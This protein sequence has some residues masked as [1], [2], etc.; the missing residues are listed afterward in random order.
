MQCNRFS[1]VGDDTLHL[2]EQ[3][4]PSK[5]SLLL[6]MKNAYVGKNRSMFRD[7]YEKEWLSTHARWT[8]YDTGTI[9]LQRLKARL[10]AR[11]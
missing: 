6:Q 4:E 5:E 2:P 1:V 8:W 3:Q 9:M 10:E 11:L 7:Q